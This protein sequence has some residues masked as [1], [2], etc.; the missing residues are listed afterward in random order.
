LAKVVEA[1]ELAI[2]GCDG[3]LIDSDQNRFYRAVN[4]QIT[5]LGPAC[6]PDLS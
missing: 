4:A 6:G 1:T 5:E 2:F 3:V